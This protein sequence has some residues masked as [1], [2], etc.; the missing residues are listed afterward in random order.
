MRAQGAARSAKLAGGRG[1]LEPCRT[2]AEHL[3]GDPCSR[4]VTALLAEA[5]PVFSGSPSAQHGRPAT[6]PP[7]SRRVLCAACSVLPPATRACVPRSRMG[8][9]VPQGRLEAAAATTK[10]G[11]AHWPEARASPDS[12]LGGATG[13]G[14]EHR[15]LP[16]T[17]GQRV[18]K[19]RVPPSSQ[20]L[21][22][23]NPFQI[24]S[25]LHFPLPRSP[26]EPERFPLVLYQQG[27]S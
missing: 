19:D 2:S 16:G 24:P 5:V 14:R 21:G 18:I 20:C 25:A 12:G 10:Q 17:R 3:T 27:R 11:P 7:P 9:G 8:R 26:S 15:T 23:N 1:A 4:G 22:S 6:P 13:L